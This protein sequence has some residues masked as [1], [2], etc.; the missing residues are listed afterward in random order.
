[1]NNWRRILEKLIASFIKDFHIIYQNSWTLLKTDYLMP[2]HVLL[3]KDW[4]C[5]T[6][7]GLITFFNPTKKNIIMY[8]IKYLQWK[9]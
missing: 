6:N 2:D 4:S 1:M 5:F 7:E 3:L 8:F 9:Q